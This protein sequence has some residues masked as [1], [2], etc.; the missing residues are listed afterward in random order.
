MAEP[1]ATNMPGAYDDATTLIGDQID[2]RS[3]VLKSNIDGSVTTIPTMGSLGDIEVPVY[4]LFTDDTDE[5]IYAEGKS[6]DDF[7]NCVRGARGTGPGVAHTAGVGISLIVSGQ[8]LNM[9]RECTFAGQQFKG[10]AGLDA[11]KSGSPAQNEVYFATD[12][13]KLYICVTAGSWEWSGN[14]DDHVDLDDLGEDDHDTGANAY[15]TVGRAATWHDGLTGGHVQGGDTHDHGYSDVLGAGRV[16]NGV[17]SGRSSTP[18]YVREIYYETDTELLYISKGNSVPGDWVKIVG[19]PVGTI[20]PFRETDITNE[21]GGNCPPGWVR[22]TALDD[23]L[24]KGAPDG[25]TSP[26]NSGGN[27][28]HTHTYSDVPQH[29]HS[30]LG[31]PISLANTNTHEHGVKEQGASSGSAV[32]NSGGQACNDSASGTD[33]AGAHGHDF[34]VLAHTTATTKRTSDDAAGVAEGTSETG[35]NWPSYQEIIWCRKT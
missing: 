3:F 23:R 8:Q 15:H 31:K 1:T 26:L 12:T 30:I 11:S 21:Y 7:I 14:R 28:T 2:Q 17:A 18:T 10:L 32:G 6:G 13:D 24:A 4:L 25:V 16:Q 29:S 9:F 22:Q 33:S 19:A 5:I 35:S 20:V 34:N 27:E